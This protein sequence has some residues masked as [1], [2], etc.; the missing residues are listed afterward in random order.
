VKYFLKKIRRLKAEKIVWPDDWADYEIWVVSVD[1]T[2]CWIAEPQHPKWQDRNYYS[3]IFNKAGISYELAIDIAKSRRF[4][5]NGPLRA[6]TND[7]KIFSKHGLLAKLEDIGKKGIGDKGYNGERYRHVMSTSVF[8]MLSI[9][10][11]QYHPKAI[12]AHLIPATGYILYERSEK[13]GDSCY[14]YRRLFDHPLLYRPAPN[15][16]SE[17]A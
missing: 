14:K 10:R 12:P 3:H 5:M 16:F 15:F 6:G 13:N 17:K 9:C 8:V 2:H 1:G 4:W 11:L 7:A